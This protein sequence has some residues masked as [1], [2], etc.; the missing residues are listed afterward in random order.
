MTE[1]EQ[2]LVGYLGEIIKRSQNDEIPWIQSSSTTFTWTK[3]EQGSEFVTSIQRSGTVNP[4]LK[5]SLALSNEGP[6]Y[7]FQVSKR[8]ASAPARLTT[9][10][11]L[12]S[13]EK[14]AL[15]G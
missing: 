13:K 12:N 15:S 4:L 1:A 3:V 5:Y 10:V 7:L 2:K 6:S 11:S 9:L 8:S 14:P